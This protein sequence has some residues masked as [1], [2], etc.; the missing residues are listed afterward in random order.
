MWRR[1]AA[2]G[3]LLV[4]VEDWLLVGAGW[5]T[6]CYLAGVALWSWAWGELGELD[7]LDAANR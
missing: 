3:L 6:G 5:L 2:L 1:L 4:A 7:R